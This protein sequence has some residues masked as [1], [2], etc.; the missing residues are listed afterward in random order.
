MSFYVTIFKP[1][2]NN[3]TFLTKKPVTLFVAAALGIFAT[4]TATAAISVATPDKISK[5]TPQAG[6]VINFSFAI[7]ADH[8]LNLTQSMVTTQSDEYFFT[9]SGSQLNRG[10]DVYTSQKGALIKIS[11]QG[12]QGKAFEN[13]ALQLR[14]ASEPQKNV[15]TNIIGE[16]DLTATGI[17]TNSTA[18]KMTDDVQPGQFK[19]NYTQALP[20]KNRYVIHVKEQN[21]A[22]KLEISTAKQ[23]YRQN[24]AFT[25]DA[26]MLAADNTLT[27]DSVDALIKS[28]SGK[29]FTTSVT[30]TAS[31]VAR[32]TASKQALETGAIEAPI[33]G[34]YELHVNAVADSKG[35]PIH[36]SGKIAFG[37]APDTAELSKLAA[38]SV[39][40]KKP[41]ASIALTVK[42]AGRYEVRGILFGHDS[43]GNLQPVMETHSAQNLSP[44]KQVISIQFNPKILARS[45]L[46]A[47]Y[48]LQNVR[49]YDQTR[50]S[51]L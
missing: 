12:E 37:L 16:S 23:Q 14:S 43:Q 47:P 17:F 38:I 4:T 30:R 29:E 40:A 42:T 25:F 32:I 8:Q 33:N 34:L 28:P 10:V 9:V 50:M 35:Q 15:A 49:L 18:I 45:A 31:G 46:K 19:L 36:R 41:L 7:A 51:R 26:L 44:G 1:G 48:V 6:N 22:N 27:F 20:A 24:E 21:S 3:M 11:R 2:A 13:K 39:D 5:Q